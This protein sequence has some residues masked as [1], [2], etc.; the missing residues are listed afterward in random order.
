MTFKKADLVY[1][2]L[3]LLAI[4]KRSFE[5]L[6][7]MAQMSG[8]RV[9]AI[10]PS[11]DVSFGILHYICHSIF[12]NKK[13][14]F[15]IIDDTLIKKIYATNMRGTGMFF[16]TKIGR[17]I[18]AFRLVTA[19]VSDGKLSIP[20]GCSYLFAKEIVNL[21]SEKFPT[22]D[23]IAKT[24][25]RE[26]R[27]LFT[28]IKIIVLADG[29]YATKNF[30]RW[31]VENQVAIEC[32][33]HSNRVVTYKGIKIT[34]RE[35]AMQPEVCL[36]ERQVSRTVSVEWHGLNLE[37]TIH[38]RIDKHGN[39]SIVFQASTYK[40]EPR[41]HVKNYDIRWK[42]EC[43]NRTEKQ[44]VG[45]ENCFSKNFAVQQNHVAAALLAYTL[46]QLMKKKHRLKNAEAAIR[47]IKEK[48]T[49]SNICDLIDLFELFVNFDG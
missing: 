27:K 38:K 40:A 4:G 2:F 37:L 45:L 48:F 43:L 11:A 24:F 3:L 49:T 32:R 20:M 9:A 7:R 28:G 17:L 22:K 1:P 29:L 30:L 5:N 21:C 14:L 34:V 36:K 12:S 35:L 13:K 18:N 16:D 6:G 25:V 39:E 26:A 10:L 46:A 15:L 19:L 44:H 42:T 23:D 47:A 41:E 8:R 31:C 33:M